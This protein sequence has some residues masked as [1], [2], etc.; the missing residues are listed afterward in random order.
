MAKVKEAVANLQREFDAAAVSLQ[1]YPGGELNLRPELVDSRFED[2]P[3]FDMAGKY[4]MFDIWTDKLPSWFEPTVRWMQGHGL[5]AILAHPE[6]MRA[7]QLEPDLV[8]YFREIGLLLQGNLQCLGD[9]PRAAT[10]QIAE[11][12]LVDNQYFMLGMDL[13]NHS[14]MPVR[15]AGLQQA[16]ELVGNEKVDE[17]TIGNPQK[18]LSEN[19]GDVDRSSR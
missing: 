14:S 10:R 15:I 12:Y 5:Q 17:L 9:P 4:I 8:D 16:I 1:L 11:R 18:L 13:H 2:L 19:R 7:V 3:T 6:R